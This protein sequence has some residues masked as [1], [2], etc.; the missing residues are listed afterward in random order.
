M[1]EDCALL[2]VAG[3][4]VR[5]RQADGEDVEVVHGVSFRMGAEKL[6]IVG[7]SGSGKS[8]TA[9]SIL[10]V[11]PHGSSIGA[12]RIAFRGRNLLECSEATLRAVRGRD[13]SMIMQDPRFSLNPTMRV[14]RQIAEMLEAH[15]R[16]GG[17]EAR[18]KT[19]AALAA[20]HMKDP[21]RVMRAYPHELSGGMGQR[22]MIAMM[23]IAGPSLLIADEPTSALDVSIQMQVL[24]LL[25]ELV[26]S[27]NMGLIFIS[28]DIQL[29][30][31]FCDR[32]LVM[33]RG[34]I[35]ESCAAR[36]LY[37]S[38]HPYTRRL[39]LATPRLAARGA[40]A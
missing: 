9:R 40:I 26:E 31:S 29:V 21:E 6:G 20:V 34:E 5:F 38:V 35:V 24:T 28:H 39:I 13:I 36:D 23:V 19:L 22:V 7:E 37:D 27:R 14:G 12:G 2:E 18:E 16:V 1:K 8:I 10:R 25:D 33:Y 32:V 3:L 4:R 15:A 30:A 17:A 11:L